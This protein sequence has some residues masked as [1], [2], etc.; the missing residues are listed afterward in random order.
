MRD[1]FRKHV[2][3]HHAGDDEADTDHRRRV[4]VLLAQHRAHD[5]D[6]HD[7]DPGPDGV[8]DAG[9]YR[10]HGH[11]QQVEAQP[12]ADQR[13]QRGQQPAHAVGGLEQRRGDH[14]QHD[15]GGEI[16]VGIHRRL[17]LT[18]GHTASGPARP[19]PGH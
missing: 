15:R 1:G 16:D 4:Q 10:F 5:R 7:A 9:R 19:W 6:Q 13:T 8:G 11:R 3:H 17:R 12:V 18:Q 14:F 2:H